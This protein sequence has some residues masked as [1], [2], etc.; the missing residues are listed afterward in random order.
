MSY[1]DK[2][3]DAEL[4]KLENKIA[5]VYAD[6]Q[7]DLDAQAKAYFKQFEKRDEEMLKKVESGAVTEDYY[8]Q[9]RLA[10]M[11]RGKRL[12][13][14]AS[15]MA[16]RA[17]QANEVAV[18]YVNDATPGIYSLNRN[19]EAYVIEGLGNEMVGADF[20]LFNEQAVRRLIVEEPEL[21]PYYPESKAVN[22]G[23]DLA[24]GKQQIQKNVTSGILQGKSVYKIADDLQ[25]DIT[26][27]NRTSAIRTARTAVTSAPKGGR[28]ATMDAAKKMGIKL[29]KRW[30]ATKDGRTR[31]IHG[32]ADG[33]TVET[34]KPFIVG[35]E[36]LMVPGDSTSASG[37]NLY[38]CR[39]G[40]RTVEK[41]G[42]EAEPRQVRI[43]NPAWTDAYDAETKAK[44][45][46]ERALEK[47]KAET[48]PE[49]KKEL[50]KKRLEKQHEYESLQQKRRES[51]KNMVV[52]GEM[53]YSEW[54]KLRG[55]S[56]NNLTSKAA[57]GKIPL[58]KQGFKKIKGHSSVA[59]EIGTRDNPTCN[60]RFKQG[61]QYATNC[62]N[63]VVTYEMR[64]RGYDVI[65][66]PTDKVLVK[67]WKNAFIN[68]KP[69]YTDSKTT[70]SLVPELKEKLLAEGN[71]A[72]GSLSVKWKI[73]NQSQDLGHF[74]TWEVSDN[75]VLFVDA[76]TGNMN[77][78]DYFE[79]IVP[80]KTSCLRWDESE[81]TEYVKKCC[82]NKG[83]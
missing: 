42:I 21:M 60:P 41:E 11:G 29:R 20:S 61:G 7:K 74:F 14:M 38:N 37:W 79:F 52:D 76:Q 62:G 24:Y 43:Q 13:K 66:N 23:I 46:Y 32:K 4:V 27:M 16:E 65:A 33:Q 39:C 26:N 25:R 10:Q 78:E 63:C 77:A 48:D 68:A 75:K 15:D 28:Q 8:K 49:K 67:D 71:G 64:R 22:R 30:V 45:K 5:K 58:E 82:S 2:W 70:E 54:A 59:S 83:G 31:D 53:T 80:Y 56:N 55:L 81:P 34:D 12:D 3:T 6:A 35:G 69:I 1:A 19:H 72:R 17:T 40:M 36:E 9:W 50:R 57:G 47:E 44:S 51:P 18:A 73:A